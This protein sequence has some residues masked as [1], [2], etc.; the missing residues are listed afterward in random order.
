MSY[1]TDHPQ[2]M[3]L[4]ST[5]QLLTRWSRFYRVYC[6]KCQHFYARWASI[7]LVKVLKHISGSGFILIL[8]HCQRDH[9]CKLGWIQLFFLWNTVPVPI[10]KP[11]Y[12]PCSEQ[13]PHQSNKHTITDHSCVHQTGGAPVLFALMRGKKLRAVYISMMKRQVLSCSECDFA[14]PFV[15]SSGAS[16]SCESR[17]KERDSWKRRTPE[18]G[19]S[20]VQWTISSEAILHHFFHYRHNPVGMT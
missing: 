13:N 3:H 7:F 1:G 19:F 16:R 14:A 18:T 15:S 8:L 12:K 5:Q 20:V 2:T 4:N 10:V 17:R 6:A 11:V 9:W